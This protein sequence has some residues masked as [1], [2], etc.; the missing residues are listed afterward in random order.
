MLD[1]S[2]F[3]NGSGARLYQHSP[4]SVAL[5]CM[6]PSVVD[7][8]AD[9]FTQT[10]TP[11]FADEVWAINMAANGISH[12]VCFWLDDIAEENAIRPGLFDLMRKRGKPV[13]TATPYPDIVPT[14][15][16]YPVQEVVELGWAAFGKPYLNNGVAMAVAYALWKGVKKLKIYGADFTYPNRG[17]AE[18]GRACIE[19]WVTLAICRGMRVNI[20]PTSSLFDATGGKGI[21]GYRAQPELVIG[22]ERMKYLPAKAAKP[23]YVPEDTSGVVQ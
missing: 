19:A 7:Y 23:L 4:R 1:G 2:A 15:W 6:G 11:A 22:G 8:I 12:D 13:I 17:Y 10:L 21:Y 9:T 3:V 20:A 14:S 18:T 16:P 5:V